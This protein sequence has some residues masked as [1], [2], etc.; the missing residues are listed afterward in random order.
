VSKNNFLPNSAF[1]G[2]TGLSAGVAISPS[3]PTSG[4]GAAGAAGAG[5]DLGCSVLFAH[6]AA[7]TDNA[8]TTNVKDFM[9]AFPREKLVR[10][11]GYFTLCARCT[12]NF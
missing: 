3:G 9:D 12:K 6:E 7:N 10:A 2:V 4:F 1:S 5:S 8:S 11:L